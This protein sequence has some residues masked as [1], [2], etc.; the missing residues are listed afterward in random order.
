M[1]R[2]ER[3]SRK[4][5]PYGCTVF[6]M[7]GAPYGKT[8]ASDSD[9]PRF[10]TRRSGRRRWRNNGQRAARRA[11]AAA[12]QADI[13]ADR[14]QRAAEHVERVADC[15]TPLADTTERQFNT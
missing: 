15:L 11:Q 2:G 12:G 1:L 10:S 8:P 9:E 6:V 13:T 4:G 14:A 5:G 3:G 7:E